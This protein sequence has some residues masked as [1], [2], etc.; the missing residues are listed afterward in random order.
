MANEE[1]SGIAN[2]TA[3]GASTGSAFGPWGTAIGAGVGA[4]G[5]YLSGK[6]KKK[7]AKKQQRLLQQAL[8]MFMAGSTDAYGNRLSA[9]NS[10]RWGYNLSNA[11]R[12]AKLLAESALRDAATYQNKTPQQ[13]AD[14]NALTQALA[15]VNAKRAAQSAVARSNLRTGSNMSN[16]LANIARQSTEN[17]RNAILQGR[18]NANNSRLFNA[19]I[20]N[21]LANTASNSMQPLGSMQSNLQNMVRGLN[22]PVM[23]QMNTMAGAASNPYLYG[24]DTANLISAI[25]SGTG[26]YFNNMQNQSN[27]NQLID[28]LNKRN[29]AK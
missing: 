23:H 29:S 26:M 9:D 12:N 6:A 3:Q 14:Q 21:N 13:I 8:K 2:G 27:Y 19:N 15:E 10:G 25:G 16:G 22:V 24:Q 1:T 17:L 20:R 11:G 18:S 7:A 28:A 5:G 4:V